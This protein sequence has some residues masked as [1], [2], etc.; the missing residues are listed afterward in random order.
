[1]DRQDLCPVCQKLRCAVYDHGAVVRI[2]TL[3][4]L[5]LVCCLGGT[6]AT[7][8][9][10]HAAPIVSGE[11]V[12]KTTTAPIEWHSYETTEFTLIYCVQEPLSAVAAVYLTK[13]PFLFEPEKIDN[14]ASNGTLG[15]LEVHWSKQEL[16]DGAIRQEA[17][18]LRLGLDKFARIILAARTETDINGLIS[19]L[20]RLP[21]FSVAE[22]PSYA[23][24]GLVDSRLRSSDARD[25]GSQLIAGNR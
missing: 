13:T 15:Q 3:Q 10:G 19:A 16:A 11:S 24:P 5:L 18:V 6:S 7:E 1:M 21:I 2:L 20:N 22:G 17:A 9:N 4:T 8:D 12:P 25:A 23:G 14:S